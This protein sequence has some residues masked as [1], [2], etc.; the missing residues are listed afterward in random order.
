MSPGLRGAAILKSRILEDSF[1]RTPYITRVSARIWI[2]MPSGEQHNQNLHQNILL[3]YI[4]KLALT[5]PNTWLIQNAGRIEDKW[6]TVHLKQKQLILSIGKNNFWA[7]RTSKD[8]K[9]SSIVP[10][11]ELATIIMVPSSQAVLVSNSEDSSL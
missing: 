8:C 11:L 2:I 9:L 3:L 4:L 6:V 10:L 5:K 7:L 1:S